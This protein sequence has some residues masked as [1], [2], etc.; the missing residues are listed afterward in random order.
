[1]KK[2]ATNTKRSNPRSKPA[3]GREE[4]SCP[5]PG[6][7]KFR[8]LA[9]ELGGVVECANDA[10]WSCMELSHGQSIEFN[11]AKLQSYIA[12][13]RYRMEAVARIFPNAEANAKSS[14]GTGDA[15]PQKL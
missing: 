14:G 2:T 11:E 13:I 10:L 8:R 1:M 4:D 7:G 5:A 6:S 12:D 15:A 9:I 3:R